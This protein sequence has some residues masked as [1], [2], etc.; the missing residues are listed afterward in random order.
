M[1]RNR[2]ARLERAEER[3]FAGYGLAPRSYR[4][5]LEDPR[6]QTRALEV[7]DGPPLLLVHGSGTSAASWAPLL[8]HLRADACSPPI[9]R[10]SGSPNSAR[11]RWATAAGAHRHPDALCARRSAPRLVA[12]H[13]AG[14][15]PH[16]AY[17]H[18]RGALG[19]RAE[20]NTPDEWFDR[21]I[22]TSTAASRSAAEPS[23]CCPTADSK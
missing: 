16:A 10:D 6:L 15:D 9:F 18:G 14:S 1:G 5:A 21:A 3:L 22:A 12:P 8:P 19:R 20:R 7:G 4:V 13:A 23:S 2:R 11:P 17:G